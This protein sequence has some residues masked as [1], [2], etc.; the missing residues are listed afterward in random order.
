MQGK[1]KIPL[2]APVIIDTTKSK[3]NL[4]NG[5]RKD[6]AFMPEG[7]VTEYINELSGELL[8]VK[9]RSN[10]EVK[11]SKNELSDCTIDYYF[12]E[13]NI[14]SSLF[15]PIKVFLKTKFDY[16]GNKEIKKLINPLTFLKWF[17]YTIKDVF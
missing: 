17:T 16:S 7:I 8:V 1:R 4:K 12:S 14:D 10:I 3:Y 15:N 5:S 2:G 11:V 13:K 6:I 9:L